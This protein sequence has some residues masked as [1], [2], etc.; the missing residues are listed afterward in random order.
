ESAVS[1]RTRVEVVTE[2]VLAR[3]L[4][5]EPALPGV[6][7]VIFDEFHE[8]SLEADLALAL[9]L[10][11]RRALR[12]DLRL[13]VMSATLDPGPLAALLPARVVRAEGR[14]FPVQEHY[15]AASPALAERIPAVVGLVRRALQ[16]QAGDVLVFLPGRAEIRRAAAA[17]SDLDIACQVL[18]LHGDL[19]A[20][21]QDRVLQPATAGA[22]RRVVL[23]TDLAETSVTIP[24]IGAVVDSGLA[25]KPRFDPNTGLTRLETRRVAR[26]AADQRA[27]RAGRL[28]PGWCYRA[29][30]RGDQE[31]LATLSDP[32]IRHADLAPLVLELANWGVSDPAA[33]TW[34]EPPPAA[35]WQQAL[36]LLQQ[37]EALDGEGSPTALGRRMARV[38]AHPR[39]AH[40]LASAR[41]PGSGA[42]AAD[43]AALLS[44]RDPRRGAAGL[45]PDLDLHSRLDALAS[46]RR[47][48][49]APPGYD[50]K[51]LAGV[52][53]AARQLRRY[54]PD[55]RADAPAWSAGALVSLAFPE[56]IAQRRP[57]TL[58]SFLL[59]NGRGA[60]LPEHDPLAAA[61]LL[62]IPS[63]DAGSREGRAWL[64]IACDRQELE[65]AHA[66]RL[67]SQLRLF[68][69]Q[70]RQAVAARREVRLDALSLEALNAPIT[71]PG[72]A[73]GLL[74]EAVQRA[75]LDCLHWSE[76][77]AQLRARLATLRRAMPEAGWPDVSEA[78][79]SAHL[80]DWLGP[81]LGGATS[82]K[83]LQRIDLHAALLGLLDW[84]ARQRLEQL[85]P[86]HYQ[87]PA[88]TRR[89]LQYDLDAAPL[90]AV[91][92]QELFGLE[93]EPVVADGAVAV[94]LHLLSPAGRPLQITRDLPHFWRT[95]YAE[96]RKE[97]RGRYPKHHWPEDPL[98]ASPSRGGRKPR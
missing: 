8:R 6:G 67:Q 40:L 48:G 90:L 75:G 70:D 51:A 86:T 71:D 66:G 54:L 53:R 14:L 58:G 77:A 37:L 9:V 39:L 62:V 83:A 42:L 41:A 68:W 57:G 22:G 18:P 55:E 97:M 59:A 89:R 25:R 12:E 78:W 29:W 96:V 45:E 33:L 49:H 5:R 11:A 31:R 2:G 23:S 80:E 34:L 81:W 24:G 92:L 38:P 43:L 94:V 10:D 27:G 72:A 44:E 4:Q 35:N 56:R 73:A 63:L 7:L 52:D 87:T 65:V 61:D 79:L 88:G 91:P 15:L 16:E 98:Q 28:G 19:P 36:A 13:L 69:D 76:A 82:F 20:A 46:W 30:S 64:A 93:Q 32:E 84:P 74:L 85:A 50:A 3:R 47:T 95:G 60:R 21:E 1:P 26:D 17:L